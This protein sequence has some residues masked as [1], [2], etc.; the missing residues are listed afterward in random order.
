MNDEAKQYIENFLQNY[1]LCAV[2]GNASYVDVKYDL[3]KHTIT[4]ACDG[5]ENEYAAALFHIMEEGE[6]WLGNNSG[7]PIVFCFHAAH[8]AKEI[9]IQSGNLKMIIKNSD[10]GKT[11]MYCSASSFSKATIVTF[12]EHNAGSF[13]LK[14]IPSFFVSGSPIRIIFN[15][16][17]LERPFAITGGLSF[18][19]TDIG[20]IHVAKSKNRPIEDLSIILLLNGSVRRVFE[21]REIIDDLKHI[22]H[23][24][25]EH[26]TI[27]ALHPEELV[28]LVRGTIINLAKQLS[29]I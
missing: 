14:S 24:D 6:S 9:T 17:K 29:I 7:H 4:V 20:H 13:N 2:E 8:L 21:D 19:K 15:G 10:S 5:F 1:V 12:L 22:V 27:Q 18:S 26:P 28:K 16:N 3:A 25:P 23:V 11:H